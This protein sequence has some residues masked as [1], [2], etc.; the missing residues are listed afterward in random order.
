MN[1]SFF[2]VFFLNGH[3]DILFYPV[4]VFFSPSS[5]PPH[6]QQVFFYL[7]THHPTTK[8]LQIHEN[9]FL[10][11][12][13][14]DYGMFRLIIVTRLKESKSPEIQDG[15]KEAK[16]IAVGQQDESG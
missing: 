13:N 8:I 11:L 10:S 14:K 15:Y 12:Q 1:L 3:V 16:K 9:T 7:P 6:R 2:P 5:P 4:V